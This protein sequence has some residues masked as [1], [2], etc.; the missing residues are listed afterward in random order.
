MAIEMIQARDLGGL[1]QGSDNR[2]HRQWMNVIWRIRNIELSR[3]TLGF[4]MSNRMINITKRRVREEAH[5]FSF[6]NT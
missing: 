1:D 4:L 3:I 2:D 5:N 6:R